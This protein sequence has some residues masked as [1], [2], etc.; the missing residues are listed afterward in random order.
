MPQ[1]ARSNPS[2]RIEGE[3]AAWGRKKQD[4][5]GRPETPVLMNTPPFYLE[6]TTLLMKVSPLG[7]TNRVAL[8]QPP[9]RIERGPSNLIERIEATVGASERKLLA[10]VARVAEASVLHVYV[11]LGTEVRV[12]QDDEGLGLSVEPLCR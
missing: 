2:T 10:R 6:Q 3:A 4:G 12:V 7:V 8:S 1:A 5:S 11:L 9:D